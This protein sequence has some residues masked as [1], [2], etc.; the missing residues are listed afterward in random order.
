M[1]ATLAHRILLPALL[2][3]F[4]LLV[5]ARGWAH[6]A[7]AAVRDPPLV[8]FLTSWNFRAE[9]ML[10]L[11]VLASA[12]TRGWWRLQKQGQRGTARRWQAASYLTGLM[13][14]GLALLSSIDRFASTRF[15]QRSHASGG[16]AR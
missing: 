4:S 8:A 9:V 10:V 12:Y 16:R 1:T 11:A 15:T 13:V 7:P 2:L 14:V 3:S 6:Q 5:P